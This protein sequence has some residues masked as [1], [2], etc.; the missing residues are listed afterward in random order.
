MLVR[1]PGWLNN[2][3]NGALDCIVTPSCQQVS[4]IHDTR[5]LNRR[6]VH[7]FS[8]GALHLQPAR[9]VLEQQRDTP[10]IRVGARPH[11]TRVDL[12]DLTLDGRIVQQSQRIVSIVYKAIEKTLI[13]SH[14]HGDGP[15]DLDMNILA[16][17]VKI[18]H[19]GLEPG[20]LGEASFIGPLVGVGRVRLAAD[21]KGLF[22]VRIALLEFGDLVDV[23]Q[24]GDLFAPWRRVPS[25][26]F[27][28]GPSQGQ[29]LLEAQ[30]VEEGGRGVKDMLAFL[31]C[32]WQIAKVDEAGGL[33][34][35]E[36]GIG[37][38]LA[39]A[40]ATVE[41]FGKVDELMGELVFDQYTY[42]NKLR[43][44]HSLTGIIRPLSS[45]A[46]FSI[47]KPDL[48]VYRGNPICRMSMITSK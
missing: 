46:A 9:A 23:G 47:S 25:I 31:G 17:I 27:G 24:L 19:G 39:L 21:F 4:G 7:I 18:Q 22:N 1:L 10:V 44:A 3:V 28:R 35:F 41:K 37:S 42:C 40:G 26:C 11:L 45:T 15:H 6:R 2:A 48:F 32:D 14:A 20:D 38:L 43:S 30:L 29:F 12:E 33:E 16:L 36:D 13:E 8:T 34:A 5:I